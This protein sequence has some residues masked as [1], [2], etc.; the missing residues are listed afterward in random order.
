LLLL[1]LVLK[2]ILVEKT[3][4]VC[5][6][7]QLVDLR[8]GCR[9]RRQ[10]LL[11][12]LLLLLRLL[13]SPALEFLSELLLLKFAFLLLLEAKSALL[14]QVF[15]HLGGLLDFRGLTALLI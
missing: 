14:N 3:V 7:V 2:I 13:L 8:R 9:L 12:L 10:L 15:L 1:H 6:S 5:C 4:C 11:L